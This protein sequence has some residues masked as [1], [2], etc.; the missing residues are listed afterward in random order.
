MVVR[1]T[2]VRGKTYG[3]HKT[4]KGTYWVKYLRHS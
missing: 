2:G 1:V 4:M 3:S